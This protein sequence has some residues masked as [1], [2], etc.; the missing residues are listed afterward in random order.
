MEKKKRNGNPTK[1]AEITKRTYWLN[2]FPTNIRKT[3][4]MECFTDL[5]ISK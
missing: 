5:K 1:A 3:S 4:R 2:R